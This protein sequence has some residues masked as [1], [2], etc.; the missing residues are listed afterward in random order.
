MPTMPLVLIVEDDFLIRM[1]AAAVIK[2]A[3]YRVLEAGNADEAVTLLESNLDIRVLFTDVEI[4][5]SMDGIKLAHAVRDRWPPVKIIA[6]SG[7]HEFHEAMLPEGG[8]FFPKPYS[9]NHIVDLLH[10]MTGLARL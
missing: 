8:R 10:Q 6:A 1:D 2:D 9:I 5:G 4:P 7:H 3:G